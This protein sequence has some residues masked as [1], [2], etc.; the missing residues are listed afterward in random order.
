MKYFTINELSTTGT[1]LPNVPNSEQR[2]NLEHLV[3]VILDPARE[4][5]NAP[6]RVN[7]GF[8]S[9]RVNDAIGGAR[10]SQHLKGEAADISC[11]SNG[12][13]FRHILNGGKFDQLIWEFGDS[14]NPQWIHVSVK[15]LVANRGEVLLAAKAPDG[16]TVYRKL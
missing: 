11:N 15:R 4:W 7:S 10:G 6:I 3:S 5:F 9:E 2:A 13:L 12:I 16:R 14:A 8:R 1:G